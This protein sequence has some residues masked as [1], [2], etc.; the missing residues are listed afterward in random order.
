MPT[1]RSLIDAHGKPPRE[2]C[3]DWYRQI[4]EAQPSYR[5]GDEPLDWQGSALRGY[6]DWTNTDVKHDG[7]L[8]LD[9]WN[10]GLFNTAQE[11]LTHWLE[12][13]KDPVESV[14]ESIR[15]ETL[16][17][18][19]PHVLP[20]PRK[21]DTRTARVRA[22]G[23]AKILSA[24]VVVG[25]VTVFG[26]YLV[27]A[28][29]SARDGTDETVAMPT[30]E[31]IENQLQSYDIA[32]LPEFEPPDISALEQTSNDG[33]FQAVSLESFQA[34]AAVQATAAAESSRIAPA[35]RSGT[36]PAIP[37]TGVPEDSL[38]GQDVMLQIEKVMLHARTQADADA[39]TAEMASSNSPGSNLPDADTENEQS[40]ST[41]WSALEPIVL[42]PDVLIHHQS[43]PKAFRRRPREPFWRVRLQI[44]DGYTLEPDTI[45]ST[46]FR[47]A[48]VWRIFDSEAKS[49]RACVVVQF[50]NRPGRHGYFAVQTSGGS[51]D[52]PLLRLPLSRKWLDPLASTLKQTVQQRQIDPGARRLASNQLKLAQRVA[53]IIVDLDRLAN[54]LEGEIQLCAEMSASA[55]GEVLLRYGG[56]LEK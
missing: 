34:T 4:Q 45:Q 15:V 11:Q 36:P 9:D 1:V 38:H 3:L 10:V 22:A 51:E 56:E 21:S 39:P 47:D 43:L 50:L 27:I 2:I 53:E 37:S 16:A 52:L 31:Q 40:D 32:R 26:F 5:L 46:V 24:T 14:G 30:I 44:P 18:D 23:N 19:V 25:L 33:S 20:H 13:G 42:S 55:S 29:Q 35:L 8:G 54:L 28:T 12:N 49:P 41:E 48:G 17:M 6:A 7:T